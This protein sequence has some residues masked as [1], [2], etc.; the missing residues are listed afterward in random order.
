MGGAVYCWLNLSRPLPPW[1]FPD[2]KPRQTD[3]A[4]PIREGSRNAQLFSLAGTLRCRGFP[5]SVITQTLTS[6]NQHHC[7]PPLGRREVEGIVEKIMR[8]PRHGRLYDT[9]PI[10]LAASA[11]THAGPAPAPCEPT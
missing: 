10:E 5:R 2:A 6:V 9:H 3:L 7:Q 1:P 8:R 4:E 11:G